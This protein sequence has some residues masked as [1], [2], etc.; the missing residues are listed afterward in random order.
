MSSLVDRARE[1]S[2]ASLLASYPDKEIEATLA[3]MASLSRDAVAGPLVSSA[4]RGELDEARAAY[5]KLFDAG[6]ARASLYETE[7]GRMRGMSKGVDLADVAG[8]YAAFGLSL[9]ADVAHEVVDHVAVELEFYALLLLKEAALAAAKDDEG[10]AVVHDARVKFL[11]D[12]LGRFGA[13]IASR[14]GVGESALYGP[15]FRF[16]A[17][18]VSEE[19]EAAGARPA[20]LDFFADREADEM[21]CGS[22]HLPV[23]PT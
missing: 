16:I 20:P 15:V 17:R 18:L 22:V 3:G 8:F 7:Y 12:H 1:V 14:P 6:G 9:D 13:A 19:C 21:K 10:L 11:T 4:L 23:V 5:T 2:L